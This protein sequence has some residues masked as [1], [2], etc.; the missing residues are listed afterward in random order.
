MSTATKIPITPRRRLD[1]D[2]AGDI[3]RYWFDGD[4]FKTRLFDAHSLM[5]PSGERFF[6][7]S[8]RAWQDE[9]HNLS[10]V[11]DVREFILQEGQHTQQHAQSNA[12]LKKQGINVEAIEARLQRNMDAQRRRMPRCLALALTAGFEHLTT[13][14]GVAITNYGADFVGADRRIFALYA[15]HSA[16]E[17]EHRSVC[18]DVMQDV[19]R[20]GYF[21][22]VTGLLLATLVFQLQAASLVNALLR[23]DGYGILQ[24][25]RLW[26]GGLRSIY[27]R[28]G[29]FGRQARHYA[30][31]FNPRFHPSRYGDM[32]GYERWKHV[33][34]TLGDPLAAGD[35]IRT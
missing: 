2:L 5:T 31:Y 27:G 11:T 14:A 9:I 22:R 29:L 33:M 32:H 28:T 35:A 24:R 16:E 1:F 15:W 34:E 20:I 6:I 10:L 13:L 23:H 26:R 17:L 4:A 19:A 18:F 7:Q 3:P 21:M 8:L 25:L 30:A 12:R